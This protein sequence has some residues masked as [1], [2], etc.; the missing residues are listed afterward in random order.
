M[1]LDNAINDGVWRSYGA[2]KEEYQTRVNQ[3]P[4]PKI[5]DF[6]IHWGCILM[7]VLYDDGF[8]LTRKNK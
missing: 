6:I 8:V 3:E 2:L 1:N 4:D 7:K 5:M